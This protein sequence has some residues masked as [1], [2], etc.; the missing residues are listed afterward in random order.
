MNYEVKITEEAINNI[1]EIYRYISETLFAPLTAQKFFDNI[2]RN[3][4]NLNHLPK[5]H[6]V[7]PFLN[8][9]KLDVEFRVMYM[10][11]F[12]VFFFIDGKEVIIA[13]IIYS[14]RDLEKHMQNY[15]LDDE[16]FP[17]VA[18]EAGENF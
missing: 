6:K 3:I 15:L 4:T 9:N 11:R 12:A 5:R 14:G 8:A 10:D 7:Y 18:H 16:N 17:F 13:K 1:E 2:M